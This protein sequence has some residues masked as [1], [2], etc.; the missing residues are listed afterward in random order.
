MTG[1]RSIAGSTTFRSLRSRNFRLFFVGQLTSQSGTWMQSIAVI[2]VVL[3]LTDDG[4]ALGLATAAQFLPVLVLGA[5]GGLVADRVD[6]HRLLLATQ[7]GFAVIAL[8]YTALW[9][10]GTTT[11][12]AIY[13][14]SMAFGLTTALDNPA[15]RSLVAEM[16]AE[17]DV[18]NAVGLNSALMTGSRV[19]GPALAG[20]LLASVGAG[21]VFAVN[22]A[23]CVPI[24]AALLLMRRAEFRARPVVARE[25][26]QLVE[27]LRYTWRTTELR[28]TFILI[29]VIGTFAFEYQVTLP[30]LAERSLG[31]GPG[32]FTLLYSCMS[33]GS[34][35]GALMVARR[36]SIPPDFL[37]RAAIGLAVA[38]TVMALAPTVAT[39]AVAAVPVGL[40]MVFLLS[41]SN[42][43]IQLRADETMRGR[44]LALTA[45]VFL[46]S[47][48][49]GGPIAGAVSEYLGPRAG[50]LLGAV[51]SGL[52]GWWVLRQV[53]AAPAP[54]PVVA[55]VVA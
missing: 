39:A 53:A 33:A 51:T 52:V 14:L 3:Q 26:G 7:I 48:P 21:W 41:G 49:I 24:L 31:G 4:V 32:A 54:S 22:A 43:V 10:T 8:G 44:V 16:V 15:R 29:A 6:R 27:G 1:G 23:T 50:L 45:V 42:A 18:P 30:L 34:V 38:T 35:V 46:G 9:F 40:T 20:V 25:R 13:V 17:V 11:L 36:D 55:D 5:W 19:I 47:T 2:W 12:P 28:R 37:A